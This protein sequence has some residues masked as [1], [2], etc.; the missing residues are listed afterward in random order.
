[1][2]TESFPLPRTQSGPERQ[3]LLATLLGDY[4]FWRH[5]HL[6]SAVLIRLLMEFGASPGSARAAIRRL[7]DRGV[8]VRSRS[9]RTTSYGLP[10]RSY[11]ALV[12]HAQRLLSFGAQPP[13]WDRRW[14]IVAFSI[15]EG[16]RNLRHAARVGLRSRG[17]APLYDGVWVS[18]YD[19]SEEAVELLRALG[20]SS[21]T[22]MRA[23]ESAGSPLEGSPKSAYDLTS[24]AAAYRDFVSRYEALLER[25]RGGAL[26]AAEAFLTRTTL[27]SDWNGLRHLDPD[28][29]GELLPPDWPR[30]QA[31][32]VYVAIYDSLGPLGEQRFREIVGEIS[33]EL[34]KLT[35]HH[36]SKR[37]VPARRAA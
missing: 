35:T 28:L 17:L 29:P 15:P 26:T 34:A 4:W 14:T 19:R 11:E 12:E 24:V 25:V 7:A 37:M 23:S 22:V 18:P 2:A 33:S 21:A 31:R 10:S 36:T 20:I 5:E 27:M 1:V 3:R 30:P 13:Q 9:G 8:L 32:S 6:P 16:G